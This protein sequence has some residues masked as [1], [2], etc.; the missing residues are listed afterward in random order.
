VRR[1]VAAVLLC[2]LA[3]CSS[4]G[5][6][7]ADLQTKMNAV[8]DAAN[9]KDAAQLRIAV[10]EFLQEV[11]AQSQNGDIPSTKAQDLRTVAARVLADASLLEDTTPTAAPSTP[12]PE[13]S[14]T[15]SPTPKPTPTPEPTQA[16]PSPTVTVPVPT[17]PSSST[18]P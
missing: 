12:T 8:T 10:S 18:S 3:A 11:S 1:L 14:P 6:A 4:S 2:A 9:A 17:L 5:S 7:A 15:P 13:A 16:P